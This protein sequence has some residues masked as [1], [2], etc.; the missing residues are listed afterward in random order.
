MTIYSA[1]VR[2]EA[3]DQSGTKIVLVV[4]KLATGRFSAPVGIQKLAEAGSRDARLV[5]K[6]R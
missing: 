2:D 1:V 5:G 4:G 6:R 3:S